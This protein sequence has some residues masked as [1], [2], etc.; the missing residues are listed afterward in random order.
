MSGARAAF[1]DRDGTLIADV[2]YLRSPDQI[3]MLDGVP[4]ALRAL[5]DAGY[6]LVLVTNQSGVARG[7]FTLD[8]VHA[9]HAALEAKLGLRFD[10]IRICPHHPDGTV[11]AFTQV[12]SCRKPAPGM[13]CDA[14][15]A[16]GVDPQR[17]ITVG[18]KRADLDAGHA[19]GIDGYLVRTGHGTTDSAGLVSWADLPAVVRERLRVD[20]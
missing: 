3:R 10:A 11:A 4:E 8:D 18:D 16:L 20:R 19:L 5:R 6:L 9:V 14:I 7:L 12:C 2:H 17:S 15:A 13:L 1:L